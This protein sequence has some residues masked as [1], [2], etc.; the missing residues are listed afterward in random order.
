MGRRVRLLPVPGGLLRAAART[1][2][3]SAE[4][5]RLLDSLVLDNGLLRRELGLGPAVFPGSGPGADGAVV[6]RPAWALEKI[7]CYV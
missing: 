5:D 4:V 2:G 6:R 7:C 3:K 1:W